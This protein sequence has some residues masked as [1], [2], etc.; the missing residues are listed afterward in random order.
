MAPVAESPPIA[1]YPDTRE[2][3][4]PISGM[5]CAA[6]AARIQKVLTRTPGVIDASVNFA[7]GKGTI[8]YH[9]T[10][11]TQEQIAAAVR[12]TGYE[13][14]LEASAPAAETSASETAALDPAPRRRFLWSLVLSVPVVILG[15]GSDWIPSLST[16]AWQWLCAALTTAVL[17]IGGGAF[18]RAAWRTA[19]HGATDMNTL[20]TIGTLAAYLFSLVSLLFPNAITA[21]ATPMPGMHM[22]AGPHAAPVYFEAACVIITLMLL[23]R[24]L[25]RRARTAAG[26]AM[27]QLLQLQP[28]TATVIRA[29]HEERIP[30]TQ[31][32]T[33]DLLLVR[34]GERIAV[35]GRIKDGQSS[36]DESLLTGESLPADKGPGARVFAGTMNTVGSFRFTAEAVGTA[37]ALQQ[38]VQL[39]DQ[40]QTAKADV[41]RLADRISAVFVPIIIAIATLAALIWFFAAHGPAPL[42]MALT[43]FVS[44]LIVACPCALGLAT[45]AAI[46]VGT[47]RGAALGILIN[48][49]P[50]LEKAHRINVVVLDKTGTLTTGHPTV[51]DLFPALGTTPEDL[52]RRAAAAELHSEHPLAQ[53][54]VK[55]ARDRN[56][57]IPTA[58]HFAAL[59][60]AGIRA[61]VE[62]HDILI[63]TAALFAE[64]QIPWPIAARPEDLQ[65]AGKT[66]IAIA[67]NNVMI[68]LIALADPPKPD[69][70]AMVAN[71]QSRGLRVLMLTGDQPTTAHAIAQQIGIAQTDVIANVRPHEKA[72]QIIALQQ[73]G[74]RVAMV[75]D[76]INDAPALAQANLGIAIG[77]GAD[78]A[79]AAADITLLTPDL[80]NIPTALRLADATFRTI[81]QNLIW[82]FGYNLLGVPI[83]A[84]L[85][86]PWTGWLLSPMLASAA[87]SI[88]SVS[89]I[90]NSL[91][92]RRFKP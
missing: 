38:I 55:A 48:G 75:G 42:T 49:G 80:S 35:D 83:A 25:E 37:T 4:L 56:I 67:Q 36:I 46:M 29:D 27:R 82:A 71:L 15:M 19:R 89:V 44:V 2:L 87:M 34:P 70:A 59:P 58:D 92:L 18:Y 53:G 22:T 17:I 26:A 77:A 73:Q 1:P 62:H 52:L 57:P 12:D 88:S 8:H 79:R 90:A 20:I 91:R 64:H 32:K 74:N 21:G 45:P 69:A 3:N 78:V 65:S 68:G 24:L 86:Y 7:T 6:C 60:G 63:G 39:V 28:T 30:L 54:I 85:L 50:A 13:P 5:T 41:A 76:G 23:G 43:V 72:Q 66:T 40:A 33:G 11:L 16:P 9:P 61:T 81:R 84:G 14:H 47:G 31:I 10:T 51:T